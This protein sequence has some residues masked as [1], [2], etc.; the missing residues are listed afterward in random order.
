MATMEKLEGS[1]VKLTI[2]IG[3]EE[4]EAAVQQAYLK[5]RKNYTVPGFRKGKAPRSVIENAY[6]WIAFFDDAF[7][8]VYPDAYQKAV[9]E[10]NIMPVDRPEIS[11]ESL[12]KGETVVFTATV[13]VKPEVELGEYKGIE[14]AKQEY[15]VTDE[16]VEAEITKEREKIASVSE[17]TDRPVQ[18]GDKINLDYSGSVDGVKFDGGTAEGQTLNIG[19]G[20]FIPGLEEQM[21][22]MNVGEEKDITV[23][24]PEQYHS[25]ELAGKEAV[26]HVKVNAI[27]ETILPEADDEFAKDVSEFETLEELRADKKAKLEEAQ[28]LRAKNMRENEVIEKACIAAKVEI[29]EAMIARQMDGIMNDIRY[30][31]SMQGLSL[32]DYCKYTGATMEGMR[33]EMR[34]DAERRVKSQL[35]LEAIAKA[36]G[37]DATEEEINAKI[38]EYCQQFGDKA[39]AFKAGLGADDKL[40]FA[41]QIVLDKTINM[42]VENAVEAE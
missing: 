3:A 17:V 35:V 8:I 23:T 7:D 26:F 24:F 39:E 27:E 20:M 36:E 21:V 10:A 5:T 30:R 13:A 40:Y 9:D 14:V 38:D 4:F 42:L 32:E 34:G 16:M 33:E 2:E 28:K 37:I 31:L 1:K 19:S 15:N 6:G 41:D 22:G 18:D 29:P 25:N 12:G 11:I